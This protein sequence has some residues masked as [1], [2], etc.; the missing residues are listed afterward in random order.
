[1]HEHFGNYWP[2]K[3]WRIGYSARCRYCSPRK[4]D[5]NP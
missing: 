3:L 1:M 5:F 4:L 2:S